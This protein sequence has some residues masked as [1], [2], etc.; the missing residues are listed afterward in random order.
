MSSR[1]INWDEV[2]VNEWRNHNSESLQTASS[3]LS[4]QVVSEAIEHVRQNQPFLD[5]SSFISYVSAF[6]IDTVANSDILRLERLGSGATRTVFRGKCPTRWGD[7]EVAIKR[8]NLE[9]PRTKSTIG[10]NAHELRWQMA[11][12]SLELRVL[13]NNLLRFH[14]NIVDLLAISWEELKDE[15]D[16]D[17]LSIRPLL[18]MELACQQ[19]PTLEDYL[20]YAHLHDD[21]I[22]MDSKISLL[23]D[24]AS[25]LSAVHVCG[26]VHGD[27]KPQNILIFRQQQDGPIIAKIS[28]FGG[29]L[30]PEE[31]E[32]G[33]G[34]SIYNLAGT[35]YWNAPEAATRNH[36][37]FGLQ[38]RDH[39]ALG[40]V[41]FYIL[42][43][44]P[45]FGNETNNT[46]LFK[47][48]IADIKADPQR[49][50]DMLITKFNAHWRLAGRT[51]EAMAMLSS[52]A[53]F[54][55]RQDKLRALIDTGQ[56]F[57]VSNSGR[58]WTPNRGDEDRQY[59]FLF[60]MSQ[61]LQHDP[62][63]RRRDNLMNDLGGFMNDIGNAR[64]LKHVFLMRA[65]KT[66]WS[67]Y[68]AKD[69]SIWDIAT[70]F[71]ARLTTAENTLL[72]APTKTASLAWKT[73]SKDLSSEYTR[74][75]DMDKFEDLPA[76]LKSAFVKELHR[77][78]THE[79][80][81]SRISILLGLAYCESLGYKAD[82]GGNHVHLIE[83][84]R[85]DSHIAKC[86]VLALPE[87][88]VITMDVGPE[89]HLQWLYDVLLIQVPAKKQFVARISKLNIEPQIHVQVLGK[90]FESERLVTKNVRK[91]ALLTDYESDWAREAFE[92]T[93]DGDL[94][95]L[96]RVLE[97]H[98][99][100]VSAAKSGGLYLIHIAVE[101][102]HPDVVQLLRHHY[103]VSIE[104]Q[105]E[106]GIP[107][108]VVALRAHDLDT[109]GAI[110]AQGADHETVLG[111]HTLRYI[112]NYGGPSALRQ[113]SYFIS[114]WDKVKIERAAFPRKA[115]L[116]GDFSVREETIPD[117]EPDFPP[118]FATILGDNSG[119]LWSLLDMGCSTGPIIQ[120]SSGLLA[121]VHVAA[122]LRPLHLA[123][124]LHYGADPNLRTGGEDKLTALQIACV[125]CSIPR[126]L[127][128]RVQLNSILEQDGK[129]SKAL[130]IQPADYTAAKIFTVRIICD[131]GADVNAQDWT[132][133]TALAHCMA[134][135]DPLPIASMLVDEYGADI[136]IQDF[137]GLSYLHRAVIHRAD[138]TVIHFCLEKGIAGNGQDI[139]GFTPL[140]M[141]VTVN[142]SLAV[143]RVLVDHGVD[144][145][146]THRRGWTALELA[147]K[148][149]FDEAVDYLFHELIQNG[150]L[151]QTMANHKDLFHHNLVHRLV[152][153]G[154]LFF[155]K[156][157]ALFP[158]EIL[159]SL[160]RQRDIVGF[161]LLHHAILAR[162]ILAIKYFLK[163]QADINA[164]GWRNLRP[165]HLAYDIQAD[166]II[167]LLKTAGA[168]ASNAEDML[169]NDTDLAT[170]DRLF[171]PALVEQCLQDGNVLAG[172]P[173]ESNL[174]EVEN[175]NR[176]RAREKQGW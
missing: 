52:V 95:Q 85:L 43:E 137:R 111:A 149:K 2:E 123:L 8:L 132:G 165:L 33:L 118:I 82:E 62:G 119:T 28:D 130:G 103:G 88:E 113:I 45:P 12:N 67:S 128:P 35:E 117:D 30:V 11:E 18:V 131:Y 122:N 168:W 109:L 19:Y 13:S 144:L 160:V 141:A 48:R 162:N 98:P 155:E 72:S 58:S 114:L 20:T 136:Q 97:E 49:T 96:K 110:L 76:A 166:D 47:K 74:G 171:W 90:V 142:K 73:P 125:A 121:P 124:L 154:D 164:R 5:Y 10:V 37:D 92:L 108:I 127:F 145:L 56:V 173:E 169:S 174:D 133:R 29:C 120:F 53:G 83:A 71:G 60:V 55:E 77:R 143:V 25:A 129:Q 75:F 4:Y 54:Y 36:P 94:S 158:K 50:E 9:I 17:P 116:D 167:T 170:N 64:S 135:Q 152:Y 68:E 6:K 38:T 138:T 101:Y 26:V 86:G 57:E 87:T 15:P 107:P 89:E 65:W 32:R 153:R 156:Y 41:A 21:V 176:T 66:F 24:V 1:S 79:Y 31:Q 159:Q 105:T 16:D 84:A 146:T 44:E 148:E 126:Y 99:D 22:S 78:M 70:L 93:R 147:I 14:P 134:D 3:R 163:H 81:P 172:L 23:S 61:F 46:S 34:A 40:L 27:I 161:T 115:Y 59:C 39:Y 151:I 69:L 63:T 157:I 80:G 150:A 51:P 175:Q 91:R 139:N 100:R 7:T 106:D 42:F 104:S 140:M 112:S 102:G